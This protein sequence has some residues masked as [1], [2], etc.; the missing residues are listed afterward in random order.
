MKP[1]TRLGVKLLVWLL[2]IG[3]GAGVW[4]TVDLDRFRIVPV[5]VAGPSLT[6]TG[7]QVTGYSTSTNVISFSWAD[8]QNYPDS[9]SACGGGSGWVLNTGHRVADGEAARSGSAIQ[10]I[11]GMAKDYKVRFVRRW[12]YDADGDDDNT[13]GLTNYDYSNVVSY[14]FPNETVFT[15]VAGAEYSVSFAQEPVYLG[16]TA[17][18]VVNL[19]NT[20]SQSGYTYLY[21][22][23]VRRHLYDASTDSWSLGSYLSMSTGFGCSSISA[24]QSRSL[25]HNFSNETSGGEWLFR[26]EIE[27][28]RLSTWSGST[29][30][31]TDRISLGDLGTDHTQARLNG[32]RINWLSGT[33][34]ER[35][36][37]VTWTD[38][39]GD[40]G[41]LF[42]G[43][44]ADV[45]VV[46]AHSVAST[47]YCYEVT[48][49]ERGSR[50]A[51]LAPRAVGT[52]TA[53]FDHTMRIAEGSPVT[54]NYLISVYRSSTTVAD[55]APC[56]LDDSTSL[57]FVT[58]VLNLHWQV[59][60]AP[61]ILA[62]SCP[63]NC[64]AGDAAP[65]AIDN[66]V[67][68][69]ISE[70]KYQVS[71]SWNAPAPIGHGASLTYDWR[72][73]LAPAGVEIGAA[74][75]T[76]SNAVLVLSPP[77]LVF[78]YEVASQDDVAGAP[79]ILQVRGNMLAG[80]DGYPYFRD[81]SDPVLVPPGE[82]SYTYW[83][84]YPF[85]LPGAEETGGFGEG[86]AVP[87]N[88][89][90]RAGTSEAELRVDDLPYNAWRDVTLLA[91]STFGDIKRESGEN[92]G[93]YLERYDATVERWMVTF[94][95]ALTLG[96]S[97][98]IGGGVLIKTGG[99]GLT[100][101]FVV[102]GL[103]GGVLWILG[104]PMF[105]G[106][107][108]VTAL[109]P[110]LALGIVAGLIVRARVSSGRL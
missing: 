48:M 59:K 9:Y 62:D 39:L 108:Y 31:T 23:R 47:R 97:G 46:I 32:L 61:A 75:G 106:Y 85:F 51:A 72:V 73:R 57:L 20:H 42:A 2:G 50:V 103:I 15:P 64:F 92:M 30:S 11:R 77:S 99:R 5:V 78:D 6:P 18:L 71:V 110:V 21:R 74:G 54:R 76:A 66:V 102:M 68:S 63:P 105:A 41:V 84:S 33:L 53:T 44:P 109:T 80:A 22:V 13:C 8:T 28:T 36:V 90:V 29:C 3:L 24:G 100:T 38:A 52:N 94:W 67:I 14:T 26:I 82:R 89:F 49:T 45:Q 70:H 56:E 96:V 65:R 91:M 104:G 87:E 40:D 93:E 34:S 1:A 43:E 95:L 19:T 101:A 17:R 27:R 81:E 60:P 12:V 16:R 7:L 10:N 37:N 88:R 86:A 58:F 83:A 4:A 79:R 107:G 98:I 55:D 35:G 69:R 25:S